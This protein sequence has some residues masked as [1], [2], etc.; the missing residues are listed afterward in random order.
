[1]TETEKDDIIAD[2][3]SNSL[4]CI[5]AVVGK[6]EEKKQAHHRSDASVLTNP[7]TWNNGQAANSLSDI[8]DSEFKALLA[9]IEQPVIA[10]VSFTDDDGNEDTVFITRGTPIPVPG[11]KIAGRNSKMGRIAALAAGDEE[12]FGIAGE[13]RGLLIESSSRLKPTQ[14]V[15]EW[16]A[17]NTEIDIRDI[18]KFTL[19]SLRGALEAKQGIDPWGDEESENVVEGVRRAILTHMGLR[20]QPIL[21][22]HQDEIFR[23]PLNSR[24]FLSGPP[25]TGKTTTLIRRLGQKTDW[26]ALRET[27]NESQL[28]EKTQED[29]DLRHEASWLLFSPTELLRQ[30]VKEA[31]AREGQVASDSHIRTWDEFRRDIAR[32]KLHLLRTGSGSGPFVERRKQ[33]YLQEDTND[34]ASWFDDF[35]RYLDEE[36]KLEFVADADWFRARD[37][38]GLR[39]LGTRLARILRSSENAYYS[40]IA[41]SVGELVPEIRREISKRK[42]DIER[43]LTATRN[44]LSHDNPDFPKSLREQISSQLRQMSQDE[45][46]DDEI[47]G[48]IEDDDDLIAEPVAGRLVSGRE[49]SALLFRAVKSHARARFAKRRVSDKSQNGMLLSWLGVDRLPSEEDV[50]RLGQ[51]LTE[52]TRLRKFERLDR[53]L[54]RSVAIKYKRFRA[55]RV[56][57]KRWYCAVPGKSS[58]IFWKELDLLIL[59]SLQIA[60]QILSGYRKQPGGNVPD[61]GI[62]GAVRNLQRAQ[63]FVDEATDFSRIQLASM[64]ELSHPFIRSFFIC[65]DFNQR[66]TS[67][68]VKSNEELDW[69]GIAIERKRITTSYRQSRRLVEFAKKVAELGGSPAEDVVLPDR[70]DV[71][72]LPPVW[73]SGLRTNVEIADWLASRIEE[74]DRM[75]Q[76][77]TT[78]A[79]LVN[80]EDQ[81]EPLA[82]ELNDRLE[83]ISL[84]AVAC[85]DGKVVGNDRDVR[86]FSIQHIKG[87]EFEAVFFLGLD[88]TIQAYPDL[89]TKFLYV[90][91]TRAATYLG[92]TF[93][94]APPAEVQPLSGHFE[95]NWRN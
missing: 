28:V 93:N 2:I 80:G 75:I 52:Q 25:G 85:K 56:K 27:G 94:G 77:A 95:K 3:S 9:L 18:G 1:M 76:K 51:L 41:L 29:I 53:L 92:V 22:K 40:S 64:Y 47:D 7:Q 11:F 87:L 34:D 20:D 62:L 90:G 55:D 88:Q 42:D 26:E 67:W 16:D 43:I 14:Q 33:E 31:F 68:G 8:A 24:C 65:G 49:A 84:S 74:I 45:H 4:D 89:F 37:G 79:V 81:V 36:N 17:F 83:E 58:D 32:E 73:G 54:I 48:E 13:E 86:V 91:A 12:T 72:G 15:G 63:V 71:E 30:Y 69:L 59:A 57:E 44:K 78:I 60:N 46:D 82:I 23:M 5:E 61:S 50:Q 19:K 21:D 70:L 39:S 6:A 38:D 66:L 10:R 35:R